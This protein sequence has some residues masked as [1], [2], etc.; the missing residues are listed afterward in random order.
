MDVVE[1]FLR[2]T[3]PS[4]SSDVT[5]HLISKLH[6]SPA[7]ARQRV[8]RVGGQVKKLAY[9]TFPRK[10][11]FMYLEEQFGSG[12]F[13]HRLV[14]ALLLANSAYGLAIASLLQRKGLIPEGH[15]AIACGAP[16]KQAKHL[17]PDTIYKRLNEAGL[18]EKVSVSGLGTCIALIQQE[19]HYENSASDVRVRLIIE[20]FLLTAVRDWVR[21]LGLV[22]YEKVA[23]REAEKLPMV[24]TFAWDLTAPSYL[25]FLTKPSADG[26]SKPGFFACDMYLGGR[27]TAEGVRPFIHKCRTLRQLRNVAPCM[28]MFIANQYTGEAFQLLKA[29]GIIPATPRHLFGEEV[30]QGLAELSA[31]LK[32]AAEDSVDPAKFDELFKKFGKIEGAVNQLRGTLFEYLAADIARKTI[33]PQVRMNRIFKSLDGLKS[34]EADVYAIQDNQAV[35]FIECK[36]YSPYGSVPDK[37]MERWLQHNVPVIYEAARAHPDW[38]NLKIHFEFWAT[39][40]LSTEMTEMFISAQKVLKPN[41]YTIRLSLSDD[42]LKRC[43]ATRDD[44]LVTAFQKHF[45]RHSVKVT[46]DHELE[47]QFA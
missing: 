5:Q 3:G 10:A 31:V 45:M 23:T 41:R 8:S 14:A 30:G 47:T 43:Q 35:T 21:K 9:V 39:A 4:L 18:L 22:S 29:N 6:I 11:R 38:K 19:G 20:S 13:W 42:V 46:T 27:V 2:T 16:I 1:D 15:F 25:G 33:S 36:G 32:A 24:G 17:S 28:Q 40:S 34:A 7:A 37:H 26:K 44:G 12:S